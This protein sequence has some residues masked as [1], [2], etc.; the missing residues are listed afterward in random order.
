M[1][2]SPRVTFFTETQFELMKTRV[3]DLLEKQGVKM[4]HPEVLK[5][6]HAAGARVDADNKKVRFPKAFLEEQLSQAPRRLVLAG[7]NG[8]H[9]LEIPCQDGTF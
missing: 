7:R 2:F 8:R 3:F 6:M 9:K 5:R 1:V 4:D